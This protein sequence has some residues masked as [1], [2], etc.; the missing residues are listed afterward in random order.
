MNTKYA[1][2]KNDSR[3]ELVGGF[4]SIDDNLIVTEKY[5]K[6]KNLNRR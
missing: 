1:S 3:P 4:F 2:L 6:E 5:S